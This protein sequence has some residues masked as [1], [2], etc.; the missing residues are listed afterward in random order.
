MNNHRDD[1]TFISGFFMCSLVLLSGYCG[2]WLRDNGFKLN[3]QM[4]KVEQRR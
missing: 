2:Y 1:G 4:P 3:I